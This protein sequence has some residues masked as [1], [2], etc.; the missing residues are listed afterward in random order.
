MDQ[1]SDASNQTV[2]T[3]DLHQTV[4]V[5]EALEKAHR[6]EW[7]EIAEVDDRTQEVISREYEM[8]V[9]IRGGAYVD[10]A[11]QSIGG[12]DPAWYLHEKEEGMPQDLWRNPPLLEVPKAVAD[13]LWEFI[14]AEKYGS[15]EHV[16][17]P[18]IEAPDANPLTSAGLRSMDDKLRTA[19]MGEE[20]LGNTVREA[21]FLGDGEQ[22]MNERL[23][24]RATKRVGADGW[25]T[26]R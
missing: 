19:I 12:A 14:T 24:L 16:E 9:K 4:T 13:R 10:F 25:Y 6:T 3:M 15:I 20:P 18:G 1:N 5:L 17:G 23:K 7:K 2:G 22:A 11:F 21:A 26:T 8:R